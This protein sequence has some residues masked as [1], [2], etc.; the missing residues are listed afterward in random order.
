[1]ALGA[2]AIGG[3]AAGPALAAKLIHPKHHAK[4]T[5][6]AAVTRL[7]PPRVPARAGNAER[8]VSLVNAHTDESLHAV[9]WRDGKYLSDTMHQVNHVL[10]DHLS[11]DV[12]QM[13]PQLIDLLNDLH[14]NM[15][16]SEPFVVI[17]GYRSP[18]TNA[19]MHR[20]QRGVA[21]NSMHIKG[22]ASDIQ[23]PGCNIDTLHNAALALAEGGVGYYPRSGFVHVDTGK[24]RQ[25]AF[26]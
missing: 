14:Q 18:K 2:A 26:G 11:G 19:L 20:T 24:V 17:S 16:T 23:L 8:Y 15:G 4:A 21:S 1:M 7:A 22:K 6:Q 3:V 9:Y 13:D 25:W 12:H 5:A 10:R